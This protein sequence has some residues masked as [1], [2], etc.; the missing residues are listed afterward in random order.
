MAGIISVMIPPDE[1]NQAPDKGLFFSYPY[2]HGTDIVD[3]EFGANAPDGC[4]NCTPVAQELGPHVALLG[5]AVL[6][7]FSVSS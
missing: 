3:P 7:R 4:R 2:H 1:L 6:H 5:D